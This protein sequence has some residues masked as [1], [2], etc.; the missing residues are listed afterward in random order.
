[1]FPLALENWLTHGGTGSVD[2]VVAA[3]VSA[4]SAVLRS[5]MFVALAMLSFGGAGAATLKVYAPDGP[6]PGGGTNTEISFVL[7]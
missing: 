1:V 6:P 3:E 4:Y 2:S 5:V 7:P